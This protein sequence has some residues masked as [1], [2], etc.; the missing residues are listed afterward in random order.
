M[1]TEEHIKEA[2]SLR[3]IE[4]I[5]AYNGYNTGI[6]EK[7]YGED[8]HIIEVGYNNERKR[9]SSTG[10]ILKFQLKSTTENSISNEENLIKYDLE[11]KSFND[12]IERK[13]NCH[14][15]ILL[16]FILPVEKT[17]WINISEEELI[18]KKC[19]YW[20]FPEQTELS[21]TNTTKKRIT[22][23]KNNLFKLNTLNQ[24]IE[25]F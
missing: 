13:N 3:Y 24:L 19:A 18:T 21:T 1:M 10:R 22:I 9:Y 20:Y 15:L 4:L 5:A 23:N 7:D 25:N 11:A 2:I 16:L 12:L 17:D 8:L 6:P 14:P